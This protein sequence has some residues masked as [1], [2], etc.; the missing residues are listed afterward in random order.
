MQV[1]PG[2]WTIWST[3]PFRMTQNNQYRQ[4]PRTFTAKTVSFNLRPTQEQ[5]STTSGRSLERLAPAPPEPGR[6]ATT[7]VEAPNVAA[8][9]DVISPGAGHPR[10]RP[11]FHSLS[12]LPGPA[13]SVTEPE[14]LL[15]N[16]TTPVH[17]SVAEWARSL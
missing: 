7:Q 10:H 13:S 12:D 17:E 16:S 5:S 6:P 15:Q 3:P 4:C 9:S 8:E 1:M 14:T 11:S 2:L